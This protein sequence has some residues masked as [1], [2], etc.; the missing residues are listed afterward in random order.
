MAE[1][2]KPILEL[3]RSSTDKVTPSVCLLFNKERRYICGG[4]E[5]GDQHAIQSALA[6]LPPDAKVHRA[7][8]YGRGE[9][10]CKA[11]EKALDDATS[12]SVHYYA[13]RWDEAMGLEKESNG[14]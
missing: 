6:A 5:Q 2:I 11:C 12:Q 4:T 14:D 3:A 9:P 13:R 8:I 7:Y 10:C 1:I